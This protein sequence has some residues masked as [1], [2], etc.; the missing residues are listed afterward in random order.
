MAPD[1]DAA[2]VSIIEEQYDLS[3]E[4]AADRVKQLRREGRYQRDVY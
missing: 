2:L 1:V 4:A 3:E